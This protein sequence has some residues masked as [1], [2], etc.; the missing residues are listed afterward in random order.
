[1]KSGAAALALLL[2]ACGSSGE[3]PKSGAD[4][5][6]LK[7]VSTPKQETEDPK[8]SVRLQTINQDDLQHEGLNGAGCWFMRD[9]MMLLASF[10]SDAL[11]RVSGEL[12]HLIHGAP[13]GATG[14]F[15]EDRQLSV[16]VGRDPDGA[17]QAVRAATWPARITITNRRTHA[18]L[19][20]RGSWTCSG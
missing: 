13:V 5:N 12:R 6:T 7:R 4:T 17:A 8:A 14:G 11:I 16:S 20:L 3:A 2:A 1:M 10:G 9:G 19:E 15:F 18:Q